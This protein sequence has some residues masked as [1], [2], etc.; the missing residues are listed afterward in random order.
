MAMGEGFKHI[1]VSPEPEEDVVIHAGLGAKRIA[2]KPDEAKAL[3]VAA[4]VDAVPEEP[5]VPIA[6]APVSEPAP[7]P[8]PELAAVP[9][10]VPVPTSEA[11]AKKA[12]PTDGDRL[13]REDLDAGP[14]PLTQ[15]I[16]IAA[17]VV[18]LIGA[19]VAYLVFMR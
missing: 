11:P 7:E 1:T 3:E 10:S 6:S 9:A 17:V 13:T 16:V 12:V 15:R 5:A 2:E 19:I 14:M 8:A 18:C 4:A